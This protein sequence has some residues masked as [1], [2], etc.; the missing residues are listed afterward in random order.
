[1]AELYALFDSDTHHLGRLPKL[2]QSGTTKDFIAAFEH[3]SF[4]T[5][6][7]LDAFFRECFINGL[8]DEFRSHVLME[9]PQTWLEAT[10]RAKEAQ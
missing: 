8:K 3:L 1:V 7:M 2:K 5:K 9:R 10:Q 6:G 4:R